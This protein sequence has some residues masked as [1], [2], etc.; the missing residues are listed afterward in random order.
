MGR[1]DTNTHAYLLA[2]AVLDH[3]RFPL[4]RRRGRVDRGAFAPGQRMPN[5]YEYG[6]PC[7][8]RIPLRWVFGTLS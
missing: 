5:I 2:A 1:E 8:Q 3:D 6:H 7:K 4:S